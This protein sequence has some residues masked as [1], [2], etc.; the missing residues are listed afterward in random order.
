M[1]IFLTIIAAFFNALWTGLSKHQLGK[2]TPFQFTLMFRAITALILLPPFLIDFKISGSPVFWILV[3]IA[4]LVEVV[5]IY[6]QSIGVKKDFYATFSLA[7]TAPLFTI[8]IAPLIL[9]EKIN[10]TLIIGAVLMV[11]GG[12][13]FYKI[14][15]AISIH[16]VIR[17]LNAAIGGIIAKIA[18]GYSSG[19]TYPFITFV[20]GIWLM[21][22]ASPFRR[23]KMNLNLFKPFTKK[24]FPLALFSAI[25][26]LSYYIAVQQAPIT[27]V[28]P[29]IR[30]NLFFGFILSYFILHERDHIKRKIIASI[31]LV[32]GSVLISIS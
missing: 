1:W 28:N 13:I 4:G 31:L 26:T 8:F 24:L 15:P 30:I 3:L 23:E 2:L 12:F 19:L 27:R 29:L 16:G 10:L 5:G 17:A 32:A 7:N 11:F 14:N 20:I 18:I 6:S 22:L 9:P 25:A 21:V